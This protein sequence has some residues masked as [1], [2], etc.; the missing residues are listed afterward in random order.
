MADVEQILGAAV[1][2]MKGR[3]LPVFVTEEVTSGPLLSSYWVDQAIALGGKAYFGTY[4][5][6]LNRIIVV[7]APGGDGSLMELVEPMTESPATWSQAAARL[8]QL[9][10]GAGPAFGR[11]MGTGN[12]AYLFHD[13]E[14]TISYF[15]IAGWRGAA[16]IAASGS[17]KHL[18][19]PAFCQR[20]G[21]RALCD[22]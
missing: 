9:F 15:V 14:A 1:R 6:C 5:G 21:S 16:V 10:P 20:Y 7:Q 4:D 18:T 12:I 19:P 13:E 17:Y 3:D 11:Q 2:T 8:K 22:A